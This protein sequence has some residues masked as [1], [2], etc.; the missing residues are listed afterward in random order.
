MVETSARYAAF[1]S[2]MS[3]QEIFTAFVIKI[4]FLYDF[5]YGEA[6]G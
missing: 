1:S 6:P 5:V 4:A 3:F 2:F